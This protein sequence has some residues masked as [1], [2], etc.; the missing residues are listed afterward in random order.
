MTSVLLCLAPSA[1]RKKNPLSIKKIANILASKKYSAE[2]RMPVKKPKN[3]TELKSHSS[4]K[5]PAGCGKTS[6][7]PG[8]LQS[9]GDTVGKSTSKNPSSPIKKKAVADPKVSKTGKS[10]GHFV[11]S[12]SAGENSKQKAHGSIINE[13][14]TAL[15]SRVESVRRLYATALVCLSETSHVQYLFGLA[16]LHISRQNL[17]Q[18]IMSVSNEDAEAARARQ[19]LVNLVAA[20]GRDPCQNRLPLTVNPAPT[21]KLKLFIGEERIKMEVS[22]RLPPLQTFCVPAPNGQED[23]APPP[24]QAITSGSTERSNITVVQDRIDFNLSDYEGNPFLTRL[25]FGKPGRMFPCVRCQVYKRSML[26]CRVRKGHSNFDFDLAGHFRASGGLDGLFNILFQRHPAHKAEAM[27]QVDATTE[28]PNRPVNH[29]GFNVVKKETAN[30]SNLQPTQTVENKLA[31][32]EEDRLGGKDTKPGASR[33][34]ATEE[35]G[36]PPWDA[37]AGGQDDD[38][39][40]KKASG[41]TAETEELT[42]PPPSSNRDEGKDPRTLYEKAKATY[43]LAKEV[44][45]FA[46]VYAKAPARLS[47][48]FI[49]CNFPFDRN[50]NHYVYCIICGLSGDLLCCD[51]CANVAHPSCA[52]LSE[53]PEGDWFCDLCQKMRS[54][55]VMPQATSKKNPLNEQAHATSTEDVRSWNDEDI[56]HNG[57]GGSKELTTRN[58]E[59]TRGQEAD[60][61]DSRG[62]LIVKTD[63]SEHSFPPLLP[64][65]TEMNEMAAEVPSNTADGPLLR[66][67]SDTNV[68]SLG[69]HHVD[70]ATN[71]RNAAENSETQP[72][73]HQ[74]SGSQVVDGK[75]VGATFSRMPPIVNFDENKAEQL[76]KELDDLFWLRKGRPYGTKT[77]KAKPGSKSPS[78][79]NGPDEDIQDLPSLGVG[80]KFVKKFGRYGLFKGEIIGEPSDEH[81]FFR[82][83]YEDGDEEDLEENEILGYME[84]WG[85]K[86]GKTRRK[87]VG[88]VATLAE[89]VGKDNGQTTPTKQ[90]GS[91]DNTFIGRTHKRPVGNLKSEEGNTGSEPP[92]KRSKS[93]K[94]QSKDQK[95]PFLALSNV[96]QKFLGTVGVSKA[97]DFLSRRT[98]DLANSFIKWRAKNGMS[99]LKGTGAIASVSAWKTSVR[100]IMKERGLYSAKLET[101]RNKRGRPSKETNVSKPQENEQRDPLLSLSAVNQKFLNSLGISKAED[102]LST[103]TSELANSFIE[104]RAKNDMPVLKGTGAIASVSAWKTQVRNIMKEK[105]LNNPSS[106]PSVTAG[107]SPGKSESDGKN[108]ENGQESGQD[109]GGSQNQDTEGK[110]RRR[111]QPDRYVAPL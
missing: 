66:G 31:P 79:G 93:S 54:S 59:I 95:D 67:Q 94:P 8:G 97:E 52:Y 104:W 27:M 30:P 71:T 41:C 53:I 81:P 17:R 26:T 37:P 5:S 44:L 10:S 86:L 57:A 42:H 18:K 48:E 55:S 73:I 64:K 69:S 111:R 12:V 72:K 106:G 24:N 90:V 101:N 87:D 14:E 84:R 58:T 20:M 32:S 3:T 4:F 39:M 78:K 36:D 92:Q 29:A 22:V 15:L 47:D 88:K 75:T 74:P 65:V 103:Q 7:N 50:D 21:V 68:A 43:K 83:K 40:D 85:H 34:S 25:F 91:P 33:A 80:T 16:S 9:L 108:Q 46:R 89:S 107:F 82:A 19:T 61:K 60:A 35:H 56:S 49:S 110:R 62:S 2:N 13:E 63:N 99:V 51:G 23:K 45:E 98:A 28:E 105:G 70:S 77:E 102:F 11:A 38:T 96:T 1:M 100:N 6:P 76:K 109:E